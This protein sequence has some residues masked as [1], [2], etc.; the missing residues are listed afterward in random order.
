M[1][2]ALHLMSVPNNGERIIAAWRYSVAKR[3]IRQGVLR[4]ES[5]EQARKDAKAFEVFNRAMRRANKE[6]SLSRD[7]D[8]KTLKFAATDW[9]NTKYPRSMPWAEQVRRFQERDKARPRY[10][11]K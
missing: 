9:L 1:A 7:E 3:A 5:R 6:L 2:S 11:A 10:Y 8:R 4:R